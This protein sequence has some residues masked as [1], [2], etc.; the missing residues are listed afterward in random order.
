MEG[1]VSNSA[2]EYIVAAAAFKGV[3][4]VAADEVIVL[5]GADQHPV[6]DRLI[7]GNV[8]HGAGFVD[9]L[10]DDILLVIRLVA[11]FGGRLVTFGLFGFL[12]DRGVVV[13]GIDHRLLVDGPFG[14][15]GLVID[16][17]LI[18]GRFIFLGDRW[19]FVINFT[20]RLIF[21]RAIFACYLRLIRGRGRAFADDDVLHLGVVDGEGSAVTQRY[22]DA[23]FALVDLA[24]AEG[25]QVDR[26]LAVATVDVIH[27]AAFRIGKVERIVAVFAVHRVVAAG[28]VELIVAVA[29]VEDVVAL[30]AVEHVFPVAAV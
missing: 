20:F 21:D 7:D 8:V 13:V 27:V 12:G 25:G 22:V 23:A 5:C 9:V 15:A 18:I 6:F 16:F 11:F 1:V 26:V 24:G 3:I 17:G 2:F 14:V 19:V 29:A 10:F 30:A 4:P 28:G